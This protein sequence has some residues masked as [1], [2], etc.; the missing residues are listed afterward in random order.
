MKVTDQWLYKNMPVV[1]EAMI[2]ALESKTDETYRFSDVFEKKMDNLIQKEKSFW[3]NAYRKPY[4]RAAVVALCTVGG[5]LALSVNIEADRL[6]HF[7]STKS[8]RDERITYS[9][10]RENAPQDII[11]M[12]PGV[13]DGYV[14]KSR[15]EAEDTLTISYENDRGD[16]IYWNQILVRDSMNLI[17]EEVGYDHPITR[18]VNGS[19]LF[20]NLLED[21]TSSAYY[22]C[23]ESVFLLYA[24]DLTIEQICTLYENMK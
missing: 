13:P 14:E 2:S 15:E 7:D 24:D 23:G 22:E 21:G 11:Y 3:H 1:D 12:E 19:T 6:F 18:T 4:R 16:H 8:V 10:E 5:L 20:I 9:Y 17:L